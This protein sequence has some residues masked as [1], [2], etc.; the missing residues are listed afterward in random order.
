MTQL[1]RRTLFLNTK[2]TSNI[3]SAKKNLKHD[4]AGHEREEILLPEVFQQAGE[5]LA[6][7]FLAGGVQ[8]FVFAEIVEDYTV[9]L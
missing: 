9:G 4:L 1:L 2:I 3:V 7:R 6:D 5:L 8:V